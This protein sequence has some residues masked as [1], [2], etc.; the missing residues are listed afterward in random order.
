MEATN[1]SAVIIQDLVNDWFAN[2]WKIEMTYWLYLLYCWYK[3]LVILLAWNSTTLKKIFPTLTVLMFE[4]KPLFGHI[5][6]SVNA[7]KSI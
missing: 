5:L 7:I 4:R 1:G 2:K 3:N 6:C